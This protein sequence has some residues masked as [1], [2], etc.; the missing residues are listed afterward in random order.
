MMKI[1]SL[2][3]AEFLGP[4]QALGLEGPAKDASRAAHA[5]LLD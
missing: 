3:E 1:M 2:P 5:D 4:V